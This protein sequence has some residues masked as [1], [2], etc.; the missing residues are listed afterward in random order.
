MSIASVLIHAVNRYS[1]FGLTLSGKLQLESPPVPEEILTQRLP[2]RVALDDAD[3]R[4]HP[5][6]M[7]EVRIDVGE[8]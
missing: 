7:V 6:M 4:L 8:R 1:V 3:Q 2:V 5:G